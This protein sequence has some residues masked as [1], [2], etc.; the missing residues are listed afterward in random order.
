MRGQSCPRTAIA[1]V[2]ENV[3][4]LSYLVRGW[5]DD[6]RLLMAYPDVAESVTPCHSIDIQ[7]VL[8]LLSKPPF[9]SAI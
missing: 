9:R 5:E 1:S 8:G 3:H 2:G 4:R 7:Q 6:R